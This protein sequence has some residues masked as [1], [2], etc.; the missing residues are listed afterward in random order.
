MFDSSFILKNIVRFCIDHNL[1]DWNPFAIVATIEECRLFNSNPPLSDWLQNDY[2]A[3]IKRLA[4]FGASRFAEEWGPEMTQSFL[5]VAAFA[6]GQPKYGRVLAT[7][8]EDEL[9]EAFEQYFLE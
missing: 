3:A 8:G 6:K 5:S 2:H 4:E 9:D 7:L 1:L